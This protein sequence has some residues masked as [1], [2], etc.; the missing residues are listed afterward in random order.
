MQYYYKYILL[1]LNKVFLDSYVQNVTC[2]ELIHKNMCT[3]SFKKCLKLV[4]RVR[5]GAHF[6]ILVLGFSMLLIFQIKIR[7]NPVTTSTVMSEWLEGACTR[8]AA[9]QADLREY[10]PPLTTRQ[11][12]PSSRPSRYVVT[13]LDRLVARTRVLA[14]HSPPHRLSCRLRAASLSLLFLLFPRVIKCPETGYRS[15]SQDYR[16]VRL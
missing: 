16:A 11:S 6:M 2:G 7:Q 14:T 9:L 5:I 4:L 15:V 12:A 8:G 10:T 3:N 1:I 13:A